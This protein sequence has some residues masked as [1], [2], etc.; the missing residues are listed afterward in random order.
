MYIPNIFFSG[1]FSIVQ[2]HRK[3]FWRVCSNH[4]QT[5]KQILLFVHFC[6]SLLFTL[7][8][9]K[10]FRTNK[11]ESTNVKNTVCIIKYIREE[12]LY[13]LCELEENSGGKNMLRHNIFFTS[14]GW[15]NKQPLFLKSKKITVN[16]NINKTSKNIHL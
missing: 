10:I 8:I 14:A 11:V 12:R 15:L 9:R 5:N 3:L 7:R 1:Y 13:I 6:C 4:K 2:V 16:I